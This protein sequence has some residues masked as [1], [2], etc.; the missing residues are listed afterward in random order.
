MKNR[1]IGLI[2][3]T[4]L[5]AGVLAGCGQ[6]SGTVSKDKDSEQRSEIKK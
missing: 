6:S 3:I 1:I 4:A 2:I 5:T